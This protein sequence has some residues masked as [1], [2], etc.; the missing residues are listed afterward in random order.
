M[1]ITNIT[2]QGPAGRATLQHD[3][4]GRLR[5]DLFRGVRDNP[6][7]PTWQTRFLEPGAGRDERWAKAR[8]VHRVVEG[9]DGADGDSTDYHDLIDRMAN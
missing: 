6:D 3:E 5:I 8:L 2:V 9:F 4:N 7:Q 1:R